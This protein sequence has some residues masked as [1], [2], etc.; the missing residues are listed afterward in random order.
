MENRFPQI[1]WKEVFN[2]SG[3]IQFFTGFVE[4]QISINWSTLQWNPHFDWIFHSG[5]VKLKETTFSTN[6]GTLIP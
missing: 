5:E 1:H 6:G 3:G 2:K 4:N